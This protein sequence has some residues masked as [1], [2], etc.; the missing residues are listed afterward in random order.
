MKIYLCTVALSALVA[1]AFMPQAPAKFGL[2]SALRAADKY[3]Y[4]G[5][6]NNDEGA[7]DDERLPATMPTPEPAPQTPPAQSTPNLDWSTPE[8]GPQTP[9]APMP[10]APA[11]QPTPNLEWSSPGSNMS[12]VTPV[13]SEL[14]AAAGAEP[15]SSS[16][17]LQLKRNGARFADMSLITVQGGSLRTCPLD[18][19]VDRVNVCMKTNGRPLN[20]NL[21]L[22][23]G[24]DNTPQKMKVYLEDGSERPFCATIETP[25]TS[26]TVSIRNTAS[27]EYPLVAG[28]EVDMSG[29]NGPGA[30][31]LGGK[32]GRTV[33]G[34]AVYTLPFD[35]SVQS[36]Q[37]QLKSDGRPLSAR[38]ELLQGPNNNKQ[39]MEFY[40]EDGFQRPFYV[41]VETPGSGNVVR[42]VNTATVEYPLSAIVEP[43]MTD[44]DLADETGGA[45]AGGLTWS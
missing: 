21:D 7:G 43:Y 41:V 3:T 18:G 10:V 22:W 12:A 11:P 39:I 34:G 15:V 36:I 24:P 19:A 32:V 8:A 1:D 6:L 14:A 17:Y 5:N 33:Q 23:Q 44:A 27:V 26:N 25:S 37:V 28:V 35:P 20:A 13:Q 45:D 38:V 31:L 30:V 16:K 29:P 9:Q 2:T 4:L 40:S 42:I